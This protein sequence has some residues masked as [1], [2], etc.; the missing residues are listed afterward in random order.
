MNKPYGLWVGMLINTI[1]MESS[2]E[3]LKNIK[4]ELLYDPVIS[5]LGKYLRECKSGYNKGTCTHMIIAALF[6]KAKL[7]KQPI[8]LTT[9]EWIKKM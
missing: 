8:Y 2:M 5:L 3:A 1:T 6:T 4:V 7:W 9:D